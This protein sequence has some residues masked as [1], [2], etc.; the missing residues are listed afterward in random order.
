MI[1]SIAVSV[2]IPTKAS[3][4]KINPSTMNGK[5][6]LSRRLTPLENFAGNGKKSSAIQ[7]SINTVATTIKAMPTAPK[8]KKSNSFKG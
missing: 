1:A 3:I 7:T 6:I 4:K 8:R 2:K 5:Q